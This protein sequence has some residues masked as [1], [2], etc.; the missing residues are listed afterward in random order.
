[1]TRPVE[2]MRCVVVFLVLSL[3]VAMAE[4]GECFFKKAWRGI[5]AIYGGAKSGWQ[6]YRNQRRMEKMA[7]NQQP[8]G[9]QNQQDNYQGQQDVYQRPG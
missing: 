1:M 7:Q 8:N 2:R 5:K 9:G 6:Q 3:V 4:P